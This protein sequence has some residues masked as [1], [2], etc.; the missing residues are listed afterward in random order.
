MDANDPHVALYVSIFISVAI[1]VAIVAFISQRLGI[2]VFII[3]VLSLIPILGQLL[4]TIM[5]LISIFKR[6]SPKRSV[7]YFD[8]PYN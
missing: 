4:I 7:Y 3:V 5:L 2:D 6:S 1:Y 8:E